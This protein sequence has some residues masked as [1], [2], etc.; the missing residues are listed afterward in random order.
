MTVVACGC[1]VGVVGTTD[2]AADAAWANAVA[3]ALSDGESSGRLPAKSGS[4]AMRNFRTAL[5]VVAIFGR[6]HWRHFA[7]SYWQIT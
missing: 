6:P 4:E 3:A 7:S 5:P 2:L 1:G